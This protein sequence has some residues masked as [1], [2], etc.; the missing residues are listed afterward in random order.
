MQKKKKKLCSVLSHVCSSCI[1]LRRAMADHP[2]MHS[3][4]MWEKDAAKSGLRALLVV[5]AM[6][7][8]ILTGENSPRILIHYR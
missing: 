7:L 2:R 4:V 3:P 8:I 1:M 6:V 5:G